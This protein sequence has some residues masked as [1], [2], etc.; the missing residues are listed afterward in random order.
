MSW[1]QCYDVKIFSPKKVAKKIQFDQNYSYWGSKMIVTFGFKEIVRRKLL[2]IPENNH[3]NIAPSPEAK[4]AIFSLKGVNCKHKFDRR[5]LYPK[6][7]RP[8]FLFRI[9]FSG[10]YNYGFFLRKLSL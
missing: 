2:K 6:T 10:F 4:W 5:F 7:F 3:Q 9:F 1:G 8:G